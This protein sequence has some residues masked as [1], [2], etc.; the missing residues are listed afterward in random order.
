M[1]AYIISTCAMMIIDIITGVVKALKD[2][3]LSSTKAR[4]GL[5]NKAGY[6]IIMGTAAIC[7]YSMTTMDLDIAVPL[8]G[9]ACLYIFVTELISVLEN[10]TLINPKLLKFAG[11]YLDGIKDSSNTE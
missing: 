8:L 3:S 4:E 7:E 6:L 1:E 10:V 11:K 5:W 9:P 2:Q